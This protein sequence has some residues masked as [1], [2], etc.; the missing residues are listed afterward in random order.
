MTRPSPTGPDAPSNSVT[1]AVVEA[2]AAYRDV[3][4]ASLEPPLHDVIDTDA[5]ETV[6]APTRRGSRSGTVTFVYDGLE[7]TVDANGTV[8]IDDRE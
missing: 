7:I 1:T 5:L 4:P 2:V 8:G 6:F 3:D